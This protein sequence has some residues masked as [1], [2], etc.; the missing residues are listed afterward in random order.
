[1][2]ERVRNYGL[3]LLGIFFFVK[4]LFSVYLSKAAVKTQE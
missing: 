1:M 2:V 4:A 3:D